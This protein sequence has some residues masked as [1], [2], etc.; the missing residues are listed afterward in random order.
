VAVSEDVAVRVGV[1]VGLAVHEGV[2][3]PGL[4]HRRT[5]ST[6]SSLGSSESPT[7]TTANVSVCEPAS[8]SVVLMASHGDDR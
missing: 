1:C 6:S 4:W 5:L 3:E 2:M 7:L 8:G